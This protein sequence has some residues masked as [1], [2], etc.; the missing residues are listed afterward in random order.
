MRRRFGS[1]REVMGGVDEC[2]VRE[3]LWEVADETTCVGV[4]LL[5][6][7]A[8][9]VPQVEQSLEEPSCVID[10]SHQDIGVRQP[11]A[12]RQ[13]SSLTARQPVIAAVR[14]IAEQKSIDEQPPLDRCDGPL[15]PRIGRWQEADRRQ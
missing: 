7:K 10:A 5:G 3:R 15:D 11:E 2:H 6:Q 12:A 4:V 1:A 13:K 9:V 14:V 8:D